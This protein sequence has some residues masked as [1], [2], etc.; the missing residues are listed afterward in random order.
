MALLFIS[1]GTSKALSD[2]EKIFIAEVTESLF[3]KLD[4]QDQFALF[5]EVVFECMRLDEA[6]QELQEK[7]E[8]FEEA[9]AKVTQST[10]L[11]PYSVL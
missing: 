6:L 11:L 8:Q 10:N 4:P 3:F 2:D 9:K 5:K 1:F 7:N